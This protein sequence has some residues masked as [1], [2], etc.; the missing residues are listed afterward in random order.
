[1]T[2]VTPVFLLVMM[3]WWT[4]QEAIP[5]L[6]APRCRSQRMIAVQW[7]SRGVMVAI[8][9]F[10]IWMVKKAWARRVRDG[11]EVGHMSPPPC[12]SWRSRGAV[13]SGLAF[14]S[15]RKLLQTPQEEKLPPPGSIP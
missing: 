13:F 15:Y 2:F 10:Q 11:K 4:I 8:L 5:T 14:W 12:C 3:I 7:A 6:R 9:L 1:M